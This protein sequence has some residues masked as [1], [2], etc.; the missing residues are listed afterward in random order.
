MRETMVL[1]EGEGGD[2]YLELERLAVTANAKQNWV[3][4]TDNTMKLPIGV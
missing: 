3:V 4:A 1:L 2:R